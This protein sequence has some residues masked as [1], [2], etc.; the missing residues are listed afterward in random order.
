MIVGSSLLAL[1]YLIL[2]TFYLIFVGGTD[3]LA[4]SDNKEKL[5]QQLKNLE[6]M[7]NN[8]SDDYTKIDT[9]LFMKDFD[10]N[11]KGSLVESQYQSFFHFLTTLWFLAVIIQ[12]IFLCIGVCLKI[13]KKKTKG[14]TEAEHLDERKIHPDRSNCN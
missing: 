9:A 4:Y 6:D 2:V 13:L 11:D 5:N 1:Y 14:S 7:I 3:L 10:S 8:C 12:V